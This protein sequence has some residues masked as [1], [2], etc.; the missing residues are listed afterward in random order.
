MRT[1]VVFYQSSME[2][3]LAQLE[4]QGIAV[5]KGDTVKG[6]SAATGELEELPVYTIDLTQ[7]E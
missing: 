3:H 5:S 6:K 4:S 1:N 7:I 2:K